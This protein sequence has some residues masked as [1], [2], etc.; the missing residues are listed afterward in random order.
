MRPSSEFEPHSE[1]RLAVAVHAIR[2]ASRLDIVGRHGSGR[3]HLLNLLNQDLRSDGWDTLIVRG[4]APLRDFPLAALGFAKLEVPIEPRAP[5]FRGSLAALRER[6]ESHAFAILIDDFEHLDHASWGVLVAARKELRVPLAV[7]RLPHSSA[8]AQTFAAASEAALTLTLE[9]LGFD[10]IEHIVTSRLGGALVSPQLVSRLFAKS[11]GVPGIAKAIV[12]AAERSGRLNRID[13]VWKVDDELWDSQLLGLMETHLDTVTHEEREAL[14]TLSLAGI[15]DLDTAARLIGWETLESIESST[16]LKVV[17]SGSRQLVVI[18][19]PLLTEYFRHQPP[20]ARR[21]RLTRQIGER[22]DPEQLQ[23]LT[24]PAE[25]VSFVD[26]PNA[27]LVRLLHENQAIA[28]SAARSA[29][30]QA[31]TL[32]SA[33]SAI[34]QLID[35]AAPVDEIDAAFGV[36]EGLPGDEVQ[37]GLFTVL[38][39]DWLAQAHHDPA[40]AR[41]LIDAAVARTGDASGIIEAGLVTLH[42][43]GVQIADDVRAGLPIP[44]NAEPIV[45]GRLLEAR[46][47]AKLALGRVTDAGVDHDLLQVIE[48]YELRPAARS[49][50]PLIEVARGNVTLAAQ[51]AIELFDGARDRLDPNGLRAAAF[52]ATC[53]FAAMGK[54]RHVGAMLDTLTAIGASSLPLRSATLAVHGF[55]PMANHH[56]RQKRR[57]PGLRELA[58]ETELSGLLPGMHWSW[59]RSHQLAV[60]GDFDEGARVLWVEATASWERGGRLAGAIGMLAALE[61][62]PDPDLLEIATARAATI[63]SPYV[64]VQVRYVSAL[65]TKDGA[66][67]L[68]AAH[69]LAGQGRLGPASLAFRL[70]ETWCSGAGE[71]RLSN[72]ARAARARLFDSMNPDDYEYRQFVASRSDLT[73]REKEVGQLVARGL[74]NPDIARRLVVSIRTVESH[75]HNI[76]RKLEGVSRE[77]VRLKLCDHLE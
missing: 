35:A 6:A 31:R 49:L 74:S 75:V 59:S 77:D 11:G 33:V 25:P 60:E 23:S 76:T 8:M 21:T 43:Q 34:G 5:T 7:T 4:V 24:A 16:L 58:S 61:M 48:G 29:W 68:E 32:D 70:A 42:I 72:R 38:R 56:T 55:G 51:Q 57:Y 19:P 44:H 65:V 13:D 63:D 12:D 66:R 45:R 37:E 47:Q 53:A 73:D 71:R 50:G 3:S 20:S 14:E 30:L 54:L 39:A 46:V 22:L 36:A 27:L 2:S 10:E 26:E 67:M 1:N 52:A 41:N 28:R 9:P 40:A 17:D 15:V 69:D 64:D 62:R 18:D